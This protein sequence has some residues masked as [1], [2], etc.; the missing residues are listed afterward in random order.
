MAAAQL[1]SFESII[2]AASCFPFFIDALDGR[3]D[4]PSLAWVRSL[5]VFLLFR[6]SRCATRGRHS[7]VRR[8]AAQP[9]GPW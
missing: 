8:H 1:L 6:T 5:R 4:L 9:L 3:R 7:L 2:Y